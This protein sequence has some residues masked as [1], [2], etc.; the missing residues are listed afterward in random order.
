MTI[1]GQCGKGFGAK[2]KKMPAEPAAD[3]APAVLESAASDVGA[4]AAAE[5]HDAGYAAV[6]V[7][8][9]DARAADVRAE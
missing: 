6:A 3:E 8:P 9:R 2:A 5:R 7:R 1:P 4:R